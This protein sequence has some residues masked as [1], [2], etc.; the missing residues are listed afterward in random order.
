MTAPA[1]SRSKEWIRGAVAILALVA[2]SPIIIVAVVIAPFLIGWDRW[3]E[4]RL[5]R[6]FEAKWRPQGKA[7][8][9]VYSNSPHWQ[10]YIESRWLPTLAHRLVVLNWSDRYAWSA[11][12]PLEAAIHRHWAGT[13]EFN[14]VAIVFRR[15]SRPAVVRFWKAFRDH[16]HGKLIAL[17][18]AEQELADLLDLPSFPSTSHTSATPQAE[19]PPSPPL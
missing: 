17:R 7:G 2:L 5:W 6:R 1:P 14:P 11:S 8:L 10:T 19:T 15:G 3:K 12:S 9:L 18:A 4:R 16:K 13:R